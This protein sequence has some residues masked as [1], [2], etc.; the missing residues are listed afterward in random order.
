MAICNKTDEQL[1]EVYQRNL[2]CPGSFEK[3]DRTER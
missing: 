2:H 1:E 3:E